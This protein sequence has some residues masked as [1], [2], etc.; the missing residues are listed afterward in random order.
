M[1]EFYPGE[2]VHVPAAAQ[3]RLVDRRRPRRQPVRDP[4]DDRARRWTLMREQCLRLLEAGVELLAGRLSL[5]ERVSGAAA[6]PR[7]D[8]RSAAPSASRRWPR[9]SPRSTPRSPTGAR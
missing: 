7:A 5:S 6:G 9:S 4:G 2:T 3:L 8:P 1:A